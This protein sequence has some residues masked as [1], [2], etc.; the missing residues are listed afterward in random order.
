MVNA[1]MSFSTTP[2]VQAGWLSLFPTCLSCRLCVPWKP[3]PE[4]YALIYSMLYGTRRLYPAN[5]ATV[6][7]TLLVVVALA[8][9]VLAWRASDRSDAGIAN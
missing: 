4:R 2:L 5:F 8:C 7:A 9:L 6:A 3:A 1:E